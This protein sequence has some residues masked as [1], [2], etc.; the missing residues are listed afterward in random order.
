MQ[1]MG[2]QPGQGLGKITQGTTATI[3]TSTKL[4]MSAAMERPKSVE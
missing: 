4:D 3:T 2:W 1:Q